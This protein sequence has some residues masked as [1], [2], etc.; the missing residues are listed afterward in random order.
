MEATFRL[1]ST[2]A[3]ERKT[4]GKPIAKH[5]LISDKLLDMEVELKAARSL[6]YETIFLQ[7]M[8][9][10][11]ERRLRD[12]AALQVPKSSLE[13]QLKDITS[14]LRQ[15]TPLV[16]YWLA[17]KS[18][19]HARIGLQ[20]HGGYG[21]MQEYRAEWL[22]RESLIYP[23]YEGTSQIQALM[24]IK[25]EVK[26]LMKTP[27]MI[28]DKSLQFKMHGFLER[29]PLTKKLTKLKECT[30]NALLQ[31]LFKVA[32]ENAADVNMDQFKKSPL[33]FLKNFNFKN[34]Q[35]QKLGPAL[36]HAEH[37][38]ELKCLEALAESVCADAKA[39]TSRQWIA[40]HF[41]NRSLP[42]AEYLYTLIKSDDRVLNERLSLH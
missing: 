32:K 31:I 8:R 28:F 5:E 19:E 24:C 10:I 11:I 23:L 14:E 26:L 3:Q 30:W 22:L 9:N 42:R 18:V 35:I 38:C 13:K 21:Y 25:D 2:Y 39:D 17:E 33:K 36:R 6:C 37:F 16:K 27:R 34:F 41:L 4:W 29:N 20:I 1:A 7:S 40:E 15:K 12:G